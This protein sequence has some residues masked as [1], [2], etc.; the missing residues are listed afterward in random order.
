MGYDYCSVFDALEVTRCY[1]CNKFGHSSQSCKAKEVC[2]RCSEGHKLV[3]CK[4]TTLKCANCVNLGLSENKELETCHA[5]WDPRCPVYLEA[6]SK[7]RSD[8]LS[9]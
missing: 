3:D 6:L 5:V 8:I 7:L 2:P 1:K 4:A 9:A